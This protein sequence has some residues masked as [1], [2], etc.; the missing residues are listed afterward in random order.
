MGDDVDELVSK[1]TIIQG[2]CRICKTR[3]VIWNFTNSFFRPGK[4]W[5]LIK[6][7]ENENYC[8]KTVG[9]E[10]KTAIYRKLDF[11]EIRVMCKA[12][13]FLS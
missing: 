13:H 2:S 4:S 5:N 6:V 10:K 3:K 9:N 11:P 8:N 12:T 1:N 7:M